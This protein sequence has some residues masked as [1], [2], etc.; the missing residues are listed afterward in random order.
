MLARIAAVT[1]ILLSASI[2]WLVLGA[3]IHERTYRAN[4]KL[5]P[6]VASVWGSPQV[7]EPPAASYERWERTG[8]EAFAQ[9]VPLPL[10][11]SRVDV[12]LRL[13]HRR[14]GL[15]W[16]STYV[17]DFAGAYTFR[18]PTAERQSIT[19][20]LQ[21]PAEHAIYD[22]LVM[23]LEGRPVPVVTDKRGAAVTAQLG[24]G[25]TAVL[26]VAYRSHG[27]ES[28][29]YRLGETGQARNFE[30]DMKTNFKQIDFPLNA[31][32]PTEKRETAS[33][34]DLTWRYRDLISGFDI[35]MTMPEKLQPGPLAGQIS[36]FAPVSLFLFFFLMFIVTTLRR[37]DLHP[38]HYFFLAAAFFAF[39]LLLAYLVDHISIHLAMGIC[40]AVSVFL[41]MS[42]LRLVIGP[43]FA[44][45]EAGGM[46]LIYL[47]AFSYAF[48]LRGFT[49]L[50][51]AIGCI[52][53]LFVVMQAT[54]R[55]RWADV[56]RRPGAPQPAD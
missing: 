36:F 4:D 8:A 21:F 5:R 11:A 46:Q 10:E 26:R 16:Y 42:Y 18:N 29:R 37:I 14:K 24:A 55:I 9:R 31:L 32:S 22:G 47:V 35:G 19:Y 41:V 15:L 39:H 53:T 34:W 2:A 23:E 52:V 33:G 51:I 25:E 54:A 56:F 17:V 40:S 6:G 27:L 38:M 48:F 43:R 49:G 7:Q 44:L 45:V 3:T 28:W 20:R 30:L 1:F 13:D 12:A 50:A